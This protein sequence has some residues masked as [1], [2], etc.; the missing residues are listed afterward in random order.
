LTSII[1]LPILNAQ[2]VERGNRHD[3]GVIDENVELSVPLTCQLDEVGE[4]IAPSHVRLCIGDFSARILDAGRQRLKAVRSAR[5]KYD[6]RT[7]LS[8]QERSRLANSAARAGDCDHFAFDSQ[9]G[10]FPFQS[11][12]FAGGNWH[13]APSGWVMSAWYALEGGHVVRQMVETLFVD[14]EDQHLGPPKY[15]RIVER[16]D[17]D[18][19]GD[20]QA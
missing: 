11:L 13:A 10:V 3:A 20:R 15:T 4:V 14:G 18:E 1:L 7:A 17:F 16:A 5:A 2:V 6:L 12:R 8:E 9:H 19:D